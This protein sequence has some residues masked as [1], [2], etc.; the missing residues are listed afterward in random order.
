MLEPSQGE[1]YR[2]PAATPSQASQPGLVPPYAAGLH[3]AGLCTKTYPRRKTT[4]TTR[5]AAAIASERLGSGDADPADPAS[6]QQQPTVANRGSG[7]GAFGFGWHSREPTLAYHRL[8]VS[9]SRP[10]HVTARASRRAGPCTFSL[11]RLEEPALA[12]L[13]SGVSKSRPVYI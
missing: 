12:P 1:V 6:T 13:V 2:P 4:P 7:G 8:G 11:G 9:K 10:L 3:G 5:G